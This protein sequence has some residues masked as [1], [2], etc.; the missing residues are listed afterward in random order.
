MTKKQTT[1]A[2]RLAD[3]FIVGPVML[4]ASRNK[5]LSPLMRG[6]LGVIGA[7]TILYNGYNFLQER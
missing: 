6:S 5:A 3:V 7:A 1:Q 2:I 4:V